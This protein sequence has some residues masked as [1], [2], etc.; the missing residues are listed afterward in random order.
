MPDTNER[1]L[2]RRVTRKAWRHFYE[3]LLVPGP[4]TTLNPVQE[5]SYSKA[6]E[7]SPNTPCTQIILCQRV[8]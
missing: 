3:N 7:D 1:S 6:R 4:T 2:G 8:A 5:K